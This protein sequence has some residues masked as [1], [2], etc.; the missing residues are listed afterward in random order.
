MAGIRQPILIQVNLSGEQSKFGVDER[1]LVALLESAA[2][3][4]NISLRGLMIIPPLPEKA[5]YSRKWYAKLRSLRDRESR[6]LGLPLSELSMGM[7]DDFEVAVEEG[8]TLVRV[9]RAIF[10][11]GVRLRGQTVN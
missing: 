9:G 6:N 4:E 11:R 5:E 2:A 8:A 7:T 3:M 10:G 1:N